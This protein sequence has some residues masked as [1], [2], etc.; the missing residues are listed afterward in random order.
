M[1]IS[2]KVF[3]GFDVI[4]RE[5]KCCNASHIQLI[6]IVVKIIKNPLSVAQWGRK[7]IRENMQNRDIPTTL[8]DLYQPNKLLVYLMHLNTEEHNENNVVFELKFLSTNVSL[9]ENYR[10]NSKLTLLGVRTVQLKDTSILKLS[11]D[12]NGR[13]HVYK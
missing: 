10:L 2:D 7:I 6:F 12:G 13:N 4:V 8:R 9:W 3:H 5:L 11:A 1:R